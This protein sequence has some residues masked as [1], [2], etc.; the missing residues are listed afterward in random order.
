MNT[1]LS[2]P[3]AVGLIASVALAHIDLQG[4]RLNE[5]DF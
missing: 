4:A 3:A 2:R 5:E 1:R